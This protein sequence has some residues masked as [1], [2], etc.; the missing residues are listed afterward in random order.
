MTVVKVI[1]DIL[2]F[3]PPFLSFFFFSTNMASGLS[4]S[5]TWLKMKQEVLPTY[6]IDIQGVF[7][8]F[9]DLIELLR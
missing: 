1:A 4:L 7:I 8:V 9:F 6:W 3:D 2:V 5:D